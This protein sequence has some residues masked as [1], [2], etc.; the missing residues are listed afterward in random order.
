M[1][2]D[3]IFRDL[4]RSTDLKCPNLTLTFDIH[5]WYFIFHCLNFIFTVYT[6]I[7]LHSFFFFKFYILQ[8]CV[9]SVYTLHWHFIF[10]TDS[11]HFTLTCYILYWHFIFYIDL[12]FTFVIYILHFKFYIS[13]F[14]FYI[15]YSIF[16]ILHYSSFILHFT[17]FI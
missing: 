4:T 15:L 13:H 5:I 1:K 3:A 2:S 8:F 10:Y 17:L 14:T 11:L 7:L 9:L 12:Y 6:D 16:Y